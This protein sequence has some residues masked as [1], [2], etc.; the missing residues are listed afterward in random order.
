MS[1][2]RARRRPSAARPANDRR[3]VQILQPGA[4]PAPGLSLVGRMTMDELLNQY[5]RMGGQQNILDNN[6][7]AANRLTQ[8][9]Q[10]L[11]SLY[12]GDWLAGRIVDTIPDDMLKNWYKLKCQVEPGQTNALYNVERKTRLKS[13]ILEGLRLGRLYGGAAGI[14]VLEGQEDILDQP[15]NMDVILPG[16]FKGM[17]VADRWNGVYPSTELVNDPSDP[18]FGLPA[19]YKFSMDENNMDYG[20]TVHHSRVVRFTG[21]WLPYLERINELYWGMSEL[22]HVYNELNKRN[23]TSANIAQL[24]FQ[25]HLRILKM[26]RFGQA[27]A[28][29]DPNSQ[30]ALYATL[31]AQ[32]KL[33]NNMSLQIMSKDDEFQTFQ[34]SFSGLSDVYEQF[35]MDVAGAA[36]I[37]VT[38]L[39]GRSPAGLN[40]TGESDLTNYYDTVKKWQESQLRPIFDKLLPILCLSAWGAIPD[41]LDFDFNPV[42]DTSDDE[43][44]NLIK[45]SA[46]AINS[47]YQ[48]G[49]ISQKIALKELRESGKQ[50][51]M[52]T[53]IT[54]ED[55]EKA[56]DSIAPEEAPPQLK[57][58]PAAGDDPAAL[59]AQG[60]SEDVE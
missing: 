46:D 33:M 28:F 16:S 41:D 18:D 12:R 31:E 42:R 29:M 34:Y 45:Q 32:N 3:S 36:E 51:G 38:K 48:S 53:N 55:I 49:M 6:R 37:P 47:V 1:K 40:S 20:I 8:Q 19:Y 59:Q 30:R 15:M 43:K 10:L 4:N 39:F 60:G 57:D 24:V 17:I 52:W 23:S 13:Q 11:N 2:N 9:Y 14:I 7:Y 22:E 54:D 56:D 50:L 25:S 5:N 35:M 26:D 44:A 21:R 27:L 58:L